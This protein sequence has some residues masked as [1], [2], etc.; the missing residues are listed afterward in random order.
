M[1]LARQRVYEENDRENLK[2][3]RRTP[4]KNENT[5]SLFT[6]LKLRVHVD[7][8]RN[9]KLDAGREKKWRKEK[10]YETKLVVKSCRGVERWRV[11]KLKLMV[12]SF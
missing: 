9:L 4:L 10:K 6:A 5:P 8:S 3:R 1:R 11:G 12:E 2:R 7:E